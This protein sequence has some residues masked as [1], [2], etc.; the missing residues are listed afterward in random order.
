MTY[1]NNTDPWRPATTPESKAS[2]QEQIDDH[3]Q[4]QGIR[5]FLNAIDRDKAR[6]AASTNPAL[7]APF[8]Q[9]YRELV[10]SFESHL[11]ERKRG[12]PQAGEKV[13]IKVA[14]VLPSDVTIA[15]ACAVIA[16]TLYQDQSDG[17]PSTSFQSVATEIG[18][19]VNLECTLRGLN[20]AEVAHAERFERTATFARLSPKQKREKADRFY[21][22]RQPLALD[23]RECMQLGSFV[24]SAFIKHGLLAEFKLG[25]KCKGDLSRLSISRQALEIVHTISLGVGSL[26]PSLRPRLL[27]PN[28]ITSTNTTFTDHPG[29]RL[30]TFMS[31]RSQFS[32]SWGMTAK[33][34]PAHFAAANKL[35]ATPQRINKRVC[36]VIREIDR[37]GGQAFER[38]GIVPP[39]N[40][41]EDL[42]RCPEAASEEEIKARNREY[43]RRLEVFKNENRRYM[44]KLSRLRTAVEYSEQPEVY[45]P[46]FAD[47]R[48][49]LYRHGDISVTVG[50]LARGLVEFARGEPIGREGAKALSLHLANCYGL[51]KAPIEVRK[52][53]ASENEGLITLVA[54][55]PLDRGRMFWIEADEPFQFLAACF[56][57]HGYLTEGPCYVCHCPVAIDGTCNGLQHLAALRRDRELAHAVNLTDDEQ[58]DVYVKVGNAAVEELRA[59]SIGNVP[60]ST[61]GERWKLMGVLQALVAKCDEDSSVV[62]KIG[63]RPV[64]S[65]AYG[66][67][68]Y[69]IKDDFKT[70]I[71][72]DLMEVLG[73][74]DAITVKSLAAELTNAVLKATAKECASADETLKWLREVAR[75]VASTNTPLTWSSPSGWVC[76]VDKRKELPNTNLA[77]RVDVGLAKKPKVTFKAGYSDDQSVR[78]ITNCFSANLVHSLDAAHLVATVNAFTGDITTVHDSFSCLPNRLDELNRAVRETFVEQ[79]ADTNILRD[80]AEQVLVMAGLSLADVPPVPAQLGFDL[81]EV[82][83]SSYSFC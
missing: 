33:D 38:L 13:T 76:H 51:D 7:M 43:S 49:R 75:T 18:K 8:L 68:A 19:A 6:G 24:L 29:F 9:L 11:S 1:L 55:E 31:S 42:A 53:W 23:T 17:K 83:G 71:E 3:E 20:A 4:A 50:D 57:Y 10:Q 62:R 79:Y 54:E 82:R 12:R 36:E 16:E 22:N 81:S 45:F 65:L 58:Q 67:T 77:I 80:A 27:P 52:R 74:L 78:E 14:E 46:T 37:T 39:R 66:A 48:G 56:A 41:A 28:E 44:E 30:K 26:R 25:G 73:E 15:I 5:R 34:A 35:Q 47:V 2:L 69:R 60:L 21:S 40:T 64:M 72:K 63:K 61:N 59:M 70:L 32:G